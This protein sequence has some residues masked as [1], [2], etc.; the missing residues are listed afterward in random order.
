MAVC[1]EELMD[2]MLNTCKKSCAIT[3][4]LIELFGTLAMGACNLWIRF[5]T[6]ARNLMLL[7]LAKQ[8]V[9]STCLIGIS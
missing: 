6:L 3:T 7:Q 1:L 4:W 9:I 2:Q 8:F 5:S